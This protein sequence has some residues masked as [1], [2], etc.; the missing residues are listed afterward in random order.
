MST[1]S[2]D[3]TIQ[4]DDASDVMSTFSMSTL[5][6]SLPGPIKDETLE[7]REEYVP[8]QSTPLRY[9]SLRVP[10]V[11]NESIIEVDSDDDQEKVSD[12]PA[13]FLRRGSLRARGSLALRRVSCIEHEE[14]RA[15][16]PTSTRRHRASL[17][18]DTFVP[19]PERPV[20]RTSS[21]CIRPSSMYTTNNVPSNRAKGKNAN[22]T[23][24]QSPRRGLQRSNST[25]KYI[26]KQT[27][28][29]K[30]N[31]DQNTGEWR[32]SI[33]GGMCS[34]YGDLPIHILDIESTIMGRS[35]L[36]KGDEIV[37]FGGENFE[38]VTFLEANRKMRN[39]EGKCATV[40]V[41]RKY[42]HRKKNQPCSTFAEAWNEQAKQSQRVR[43]RPES[44]YY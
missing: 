42:M 14:E 21:A 31:R 36:K 44:F 19:P 43:Q 8:S 34:P 38:N 30:I 12:E 6:E 4:N 13:M 17:N 33:A 20:R 29:T 40:I 24:T 1:S 27:L 32:F 3:S 18:W 10:R 28:R 37:S 26:D 7:R 25:G 22:Q 9:G 39:F 41:K 5:S 15:T 23:I 35:L 2:Q 11:L 16:W